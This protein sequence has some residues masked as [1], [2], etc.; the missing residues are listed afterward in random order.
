MTAKAYIDFEV[1]SAVDLRKTGAHLYS[2]HPTTDIICLAWAIG[3]GPVQICRHLEGL[4]AAPVEL[5]Q[6]IMQGVTVCAH[7][8][9]FEK[10]I[11]NNVCNKKYGWPPLPVEQLDCTMVRAYSMGLMG[12]LE[13][14]A[15]CLGIPHKKDMA[16][17]RVMLQL[18]KP[19][20]VCKETG[21]ITWWERADSK[22]KLDIGKKYDDTYKY[23]MQDLV[24]HRECDKRLSPLDEAERL[25]WLVDQRINDRGVHIDVAAVTNAIALAQ[26]EQQR[27]HSRMRE[28][29]GNAV[30]SCN[31]H[32]AFK[33]W[34]NTFDGVQTDSVDKAS[35]KDLLERDDLEPVLREALLCRQDAAKSSINKLT[36][37]IESCADDGRSRGC[38]Q[39]HGA[40]STGRWA[41][42]RIQLQNFPRP[43]FMK[44]PAVEDVLGKLAGATA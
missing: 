12:A 4:D 20:R 5:F 19:R 33:Q 15:P 21:A 11:W 2:I 13:N 23:C 36:R 35:V 39:F 8:A 40:A 3:D 22:G 44:Q 42:R 1:R 6:A 41:G 34:V 10:V 27:L 14:T 25:T 29:T 17:H 24:V 28:L 38:F 31:A 30:G 7:N 37:M 18:A 32:V 16:G 26:A 9:Q 43:K